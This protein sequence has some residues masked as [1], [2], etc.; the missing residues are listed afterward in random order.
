MSGASRL[1]NIYKVKDFRE[2]VITVIH[3]DD[4]LKILMVQKICTFSCECYH[5]LVV[6][7][8]TPRGKQALRSINSRVSEAI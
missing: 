2:T 5:D 3:L 6:V 4:S 7:I 1:L 8:T